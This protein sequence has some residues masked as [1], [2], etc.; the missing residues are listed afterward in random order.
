MLLKS[1]AKINLFLNIVKKRNDGFHNIETYFQIISLFDEII[2]NI[3]PG[4]KID[5][6]SDNIFMSCDD[7]LCV[8]AAEL[9]RNYVEGGVNLNASIRLLK[10]IPVGG[11]LGGG[12]SN[13]AFVLLGLNELWK[14]NLKKN[15]LLDLG[16]K[17]GSDVPIFIN[18]FSAYGEKKGTDLT[19]YGLEK[20]YFLIVDSGIHVSSKTMYEKYKI[21]DCIKHI[22]LDNM[23]QNIGYNSFEDLLCSENPEVEDLLK[24]L[25]K[26]NN[27]AVSGS[28]GCL[29]SMFD[30]EASAKNISKFIPNKY[31]T[32]IVHSLNRI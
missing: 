3:I 2:L 8:R 22:N 25:R 10:N 29:F 6:T 30:D 21:K 27:G 12:S 9:L 7:N 26:H 31:Q 28:G 13:A 11:G 15:E 19:E 18:G 23:H 24:I 17:L 16:E 1:P 32:Y 4:T 5:F 14:C 20:K